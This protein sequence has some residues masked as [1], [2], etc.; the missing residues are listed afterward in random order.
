MLSKTS[1]QV[2]SYRERTKWMCFLI[3]DDGLLEKY[4]T[5]W[6][7]V[8]ADIKKEFDS[9]PVYNEHFLKTKI[10]SH[11]NEAADFYDK[12]LPKVDS[13]HT[14]LAVTSLDSA[15]KKD[16]YYCLKLFLKE[17]KYIEK[18]LIKHI[19]DNLC[20]FSS[21]NESDDEEE[22]QIKD[23]TITFLGS[24]FENVFFSC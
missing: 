7:K 12:N 1:A 2:K 4:N 3:K 23:M 9:E 11:D 8:S 6:N 22:E 13:N 24:N 18:K 17:C 16:G 15:F 19:N 10:K 20:D 21:S 14:C 5:V